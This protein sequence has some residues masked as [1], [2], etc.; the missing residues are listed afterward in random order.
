METMWTHAAIVV[1][2]EMGPA[3][4]G[5]PNLETEYLLNDHPFRWGTHRFCN[6]RY[7][8]CFTTSSAK[9]SIESM[10]MPISATECLEASGQG[11]HIYN[12]SARLFCGFNATRTGT[13]AVRRLKKA[14]GE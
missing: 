9:Q 7:C 10:K 5:N 3:R 1:R 12:L 4:L 2:H 11:V 8:R 6:P 13:V 14:P